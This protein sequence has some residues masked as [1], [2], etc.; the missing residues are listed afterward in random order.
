MITRIVL[1]LLTN[2]AVI[3]L[4]S[5]ALSLFGF[6][7]YFDG[8]SINMESLFLFALIFGMSGAFVSLLLSKFI[9]K[10][11]LKVET[12]DP[13]TEAN[14]DFILIHE[15]TQAA[16]N[17]VGI[18]HIEVGVY[19]D[20]NPNAFATGAFKN[21]ALIALSTGL[22]ENMT[23]DEIEGVIAHEVAHISNGDMVTMTL[24]QGVIDTFVIFVA[25]ILGNAI[26]RYVFRNEDGPGWVFYI[27]SFILEI[28]LGFLASAIT[29]WFS[30][31]R[32]YRADE[33]GASIAGKHKMIAA[34]TR[35]S[36]LE[37]KPLPEKMKAFGIF[38]KT[39]L[40]SSHPPLD[41]RID[42]LKS[43]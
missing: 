16:A 17:K 6:S 7:G 19:V 9:A 39:G 29:M 5:F 13:A 22:I 24:L 28:I 4:A 1:F 32:E 10:K 14:S 42:A 3:A 2:I 34:L 18:K 27:T 21:S 11:T 38:G 37:S 40:F 12:I 30:R 41:S 23:Q 36:K 26:D 20:S 33:G 8:S 43:L 35:I 31:R 25:R 15:L